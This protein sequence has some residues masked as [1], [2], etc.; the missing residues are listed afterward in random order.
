MEAG[1]DALRAANA[2]LAEADERFRASLGGGD[3][4]QGAPLGW[5]EARALGEIEPFSAGRPTSPMTVRG[6]GDRA[7]ADRV[8]SSV[9]PEAIRLDAAGGILEGDGAGWA[10]DLLRQADEASAAATAQA[11]TRHPS[12]GGR[13]E[14]GRQHASRKAGRASDSNA[15]AAYSDPLGATAPA[16]QAGRKAVRSGNKGRLAS[17]GRAGRSMPRVGSASSAAGLRPGPRGVARR[18]DGAV[19]EAWGGAPDETEGA[20][21]RQRAPRPLPALRPASGGDGGAPGSPEGLGGS[22]VAG[23]ADAARRLARRTAGLRTLAETSVVDMALA[24]RSGAAHASAWALSVTKGAGTSGRG[25]AVA[26]PLR[27]VRGGPWSGQSWS[28]RGSREE[29]KDEEGDASGEDPAA[30]SAVESVL[31]PDSPFALPHGYAALAAA[32]R[33][34]VGAPPAP[35]APQGGRAR[36]K[37]IRGGRGGG[38]GGA[39]PGRT[40][41]RQRLERAS[42]TLMRTRFRGTGRAP[43]GPPDLLAE[44]KGGSARPLSRGAGGAAAPERAQRALAWVVSEAESLWDALAA[45]C[46]RQPDPFGA[47]SGAAEPPASPLD[48]IPAAVAEHLRATLGVPSTAWAHVAL[49]CRGLEAHRAA[50]AELAA[51]AD[52]LRGLLPAASARAFLRCRAVVQSE[53]GLRFA[54]ADKVATGRAAAAA[55]LPREMAV[56]VLTDTRAG[57]DDRS[58][59]AAFVTGHAARRVIARL[60]ERARDH[61]A[62]LPPDDAAAGSGWESRLA[63][64]TADRAAAGADDGPPADDAAAPAPPLLTAGER[65][66]RDWVWAAATRSGVVRRVPGRDVPMCPAA[67]FAAWL[68]GLCRSAPDDVAAA[69]SMMARARAK[70]AATGDDGEGGDSMAPGSLS[71]LQRAMAAGKRAEEVRAL[72]KAAAARLADAEGEEARLRASAKRARKRYGAARHAEDDGRGGGRGVGGARGSTAG[73]KQWGGVASASALASPGEDP[74]NDFGATT[75]GA[76][77]AEEGATGRLRAA[78]EMAA[79]QTAVMDAAAERAARQREA[80]ALLLERRRWEAEEREAWRDV[81]QAEAVSAE[82]AAEAAAPGRGGGRRGRGARSGPRPKPSRVAAVPGAGAFAPSE[83]WSPGAVLFH[84][85]VQR[86][87]RAERRAGESAA[88]AAAAAGG[89]GAEAREAL[90]RMA[91]RIQWAWKRRVARVRL[92]QLAARGREHARLNREARRRGEAAARE[93]ALLADVEARAREQWHLGR[94]MALRVLGRRLAASFTTWAGTARQQKAARRGLRLALRGRFR[95]WAGTAVGTRRQ[96]AAA[97]RI[98]GWWR[99]AAAVGAARALA[100]VLAGQRDSSA[101]VISRILLRTTAAAFHGLRAR[102]AA[103]RRARHAAARM[104]KRPAHRSLRAWAAWHRA[105]AEARLAAAQWCQSRWRGRSVRWAVTKSVCATRIQRLWRRRKERRLAAAILEARRQVLERARLAGRRIL[106]RGV[107][108]S[109][110]A[111][112]DRVKGRRAARR[113]ARRVL[114]GSLRERVAGWGRYTLAAAEA[115]AYVAVQVQRLARRRRALVAA[116]RIVRR[117]RAAAAVQAWWRSVQA[118]ASFRRALASDRAGRTIQRVWRGALARL[119]ARRRRRRRASATR[120]QA[121]WRGFATRRD[122]WWRQQEELLAAVQAGDYTAV[123]RTLE[124]WGAWAASVTDRA[125]YTAVMRAALHGRKRVLKLLLRWGADPNQAE[126]RGGRAALHLL[127]AAPPFPNQAEVLTY[128]VT[129]GA[130]PDAA[131]AEGRRPL[132][133]VADRGTLPL[134]TALLGLRADAEAVDARRRSPL[135]T[136]AEAGTASVVQ[137]LLTSTYPASALAR[138]ADARTPLHLAAAA[139]HAPCVR[140][141]VDVGRAA[142]SAR[143]GD[144]QTALHLACA[145]DA[146]AP[147]GADHFD[148][149]ATFLIARGADPAVLDSLGRSALHAAAEAGRVRTIAILF[150]ADA[151]VRGRSLAGDT[152]L[153]AAVR[154]GRPEAVAAVLAHGATPDDRNARGM[155][156]VHLACSLGRVTCLRELFRHECDP[157]LRSFEGLTA[158]G[159][160]RI[161]GQK[162]AEAALLEEFVMVE[163]DA[164]GR[165]VR[166]LEVLT[167]A[168]AEQA[169]LA[170]GKLGPPGQEP[171]PSVASAASTGAAVT[172]ANGRPLALQDEPDGAGGEGQAGGAEGGYDSGPRPAGKGGSAPSSL[173]PRPIATSGAQARG[174]GPLVSPFRVAAP[175]PPPG[176]SPA[177]RTPDGSEGAVAAG[178]TEAG[179]GPRL[180]GVAVAGGEPRRGRRA[181]VVQRVG[182]RAGAG[183]ARWAAEPED[184]DDTD[185]EADP[186]GGGEDGASSAFLNESVAFG[187]ESSILSGGAAGADDDGDDLDASSVMSAG[188]GGL[189]LAS[190]AALAAHAGRPGPGRDADE[191]LAD[192][193]GRRLDV[194]L[195]SRDAE[196]RA[197]ERRARLADGGRYWFNTATGEARAERPPVLGGGWEAVF[198]TETGK[199]VWRDPETGKVS[200]SDPEAVAAA[201][202]ARKGDGRREARR[203]GGTDALPSRVVLRRRRDPMRDEVGEDAV[204]DYAEE[205]RRLAAEVTESRRRIKAARRIQ[206]GWR[207]SRALRAL[208]AIRKMRRAAVEVQRYV[209]GWQARAL[210]ARMRVE[211]AAA[212]SVQRSW[213]GAVGRRQWFDEWQRQ[214]TEWGATSIQ[215][216]LRGFRGRRL[217]NTVR[218]RR[219]AWAAPSDVAHW[220]AVASVCWPPLRR[221]RGWLE[222]AVVPPRGSPLGLRRWA[223]LEAAVQ[224][225]KAAGRGVDA[226]PGG[227]TTYAQLDRDGGAAEAER[228]GTDGDAGA[229]LDDPILPR[230]PYTARPNV[231]GDAARVYVRWRPWAPGEGAEAPAVRFGPH[232]RP[233]FPGLD[234]GAEDALLGGLVSDDGRAAAASTAERSAA[235][236]FAGA[237]AAGRASGSQPAGSPGTSPSSRRGAAA[238]TVAGSDGATAGSKPAAPAGRKRWG[239]GASPGAASASESGSPLSAPP[240]RPGRAVSSHAS[241]RVWKREEGRV[242]QPRA[243]L[244]AERRAVVAADQLRR[245]GWTDEEEAAARSVQW[246]VKQARR[247]REET[248]RRR[249]V[250]MMEAAQDLYLDDPRS[251]PRRMNYALYC[252]S[253]GRGLPRARPVYLGLVDHMTRRGP[254]HP[255]ILYGFCLLLA[256][257][258]E[259]DMEVVEA[260]AQR[261]ARADEARGGGSFA[262]AERGFF[263]E[264]LRRAPDDAEALLGMALVHTFVHGDVDTAE[265]LFL[266][267]MAANPTRPGLVEA[268]SYALVARGGRDYDG[269]EAYRRLLEKRATNEASDVAARTLQAEKGRFAL[270]AQ[271]VWRGYRVRDAVAVLRSTVEAEGTPLR[272]WE[273]TDPGNGGAAYWHHEASG[274]SEW[275]RPTLLAAWDGLRACGAVTGL[276]VVTGAGCELAGL[277]RGGWPRPGPD[278]WRR[279]RDGRG[280]ERLLAQRYS[281]DGRE[282]DRAAD[283]GAEDACPPKGRDPLLHGADPRAWEVHATASGPKAGRPYWF[284]PSTGESRWRPLRWSREPALMVA[285]GL[286]TRRHASRHANA[287]ALTGEGD[288]L[289]YARLVMSGGAANFDLGEVRRAEQAERARAHSRGSSRAMRAKSP[290]VGI[291]RRRRL[292]QASAANMDAPLGVDMSD[293]APPELQS[294]KGAGNGHWLRTEEPPSGGR[295]AYEQG[296]V[297]WVNNVTGEVFEGRE[298]PGA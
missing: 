250:A 246:F 228:A 10:R 239:G 193:V 87:V 93:A 195:V 204:A 218:A 179:P 1:R 173:S 163:L 16:R 174:Q 28:E 261:A 171:A 224:E 4:A 225:A 78:E 248:A 54:A 111:W 115:R 88:A 159:E 295:E 77:R 216:V 59:A 257:T 137:A 27:P 61:I 227:F 120:I 251:V 189:A 98:Q 167:R 113:M 12:R 168:Q 244:R 206:G 134:L 7:P 13:G 267:A 177:P 200:A 176:Q 192:G 170:G 293:V 287:P 149:V 298:P 95:S 297:V 121:A 84:M 23:K 89:R 238:A 92:G 76:G 18:G 79:G 151:D 72:E 52:A 253:V 275:M 229:Y 194:Q 219:H 75:D 20:G 220:R 285:L 40:A 112:R 191:H 199:V 3:A 166:R 21:R 49:L 210:A 66:L 83:W 203:P 252:Q 58:S 273:R 43:G 46:Q 272:G 35:A 22:A 256:A 41:A 178:A 165:A 201:R 262:D 34:V 265:P 207:Q 294:G 175:G 144:G 148:D 169:S 33:I 124:A 37:G 133:A 235:V 241:H 86:A 57:P 288:A 292:D 26:G 182:A 240:R 205:Q 185:E 184:D 60:L 73:A 277:W 190:G 135:H 274:R 117:N 242:E 104:A 82:A 51:L 270:A 269:H 232:H 268:F 99:K 19:A 70:R 209:R 280:F 146:S 11:R 128:L 226:S 132:H 212:L 85:A 116:R 69:A 32:L 233:R 80:A 130:D 31:A 150:E 237:A 290:P 125:G 157:N 15:A 213:R 123:R 126:P 198:D 215:R 230:L 156:A 131:D 284:N 38:T 107:W 118:R 114:A 180:D 81:Q 181:S 197:W 282:A 62:P 223:A 30:G 208:K 48:D 142:V 196:A 106:L 254:D 129:R 110:R 161:R 278:G 259:E 127:C 186:T 222:L 188:G 45:A 289:E 160:A 236:I 24:E 65:R 296:I 260:L 63:A 234:L 108:A 276:G 155:T 2:V 221:W 231:P 74:T 67:P 103:A 14:R 138:D 249:A 217:A 102:T 183:V 91:M 6:G 97:L 68:A 36:G 243:W 153:H 255:L 245:R 136:A 17:T 50:C 105:A 101:R 291:S 162:A 139:G 211:N 53:C 152:P 214:T 172:D 140:L 187:G 271:R 266:A 94:G 164:A 71:L 56:V 264:A 29:E 122:V 9:P 147:G 247:L 42:S 47:A 55:S 281:P 258:M 283:P 158:L 8:S 145:A 286:V 119:E 109:I 263:G 202:L 279:R 5:G 25:G 143:R 44:T 154:A 90:A 96:R 100:R 39:G 64:T 141:L